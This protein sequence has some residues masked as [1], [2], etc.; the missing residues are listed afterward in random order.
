MKC[1]QI[2]AVGYFNHRSKV[3]Q[4]LGLRALHT[5]VAGI[6][7]RRMLHVETVLIGQS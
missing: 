3:T 1:P 4:E 7:V 2:C 6:N 5:R